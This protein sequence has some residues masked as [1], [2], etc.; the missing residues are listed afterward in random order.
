MTTDQQA[1]GGVGT[2]MLFE[3]DRIRVWEMRLAPGESTAVHEHEYDYVMIQIAGDKVAADFE[4][5]SKDPWGGAQ[6]GRVE[7]EVANGNVLFTE[8]GGKEK[9][10]NIG[11]EPFYEIIVELKD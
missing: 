7:G 2:K 5:D 9:A 6:L 4:P 8:R 11:N 1:L 3:N 10:V